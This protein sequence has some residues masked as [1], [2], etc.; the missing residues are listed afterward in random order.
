M[1]NEKRSRFLSIGWVKILY[2]LVYSSYGATAVYFSLYYRR[3]GLGSAEIGALLS[4]QPLVM[5]LAGPLW[6]ALADGLG[7]R[8]RLLTLV[9][10][11]SVLPML[12]M[13]LVGGNFWWLAALNALYALFLGPIQPLTDTLALD[14][15]GDDQR[16]R[17]SEIRAFGSLGYA[18]V[19]WLTGMW[20]TGHDIRWIFVGY[21]VL[22][23][24]GALLSVWVRSSGAALKTRVG[25]GLGVLLR[26][27]AWQVFAGALF[28]S[29][30]AQQVTFSFVGLYL[31][32]LGA[33]EGLIGFSS[34]LGSVT[35]TLLMLGALSWMLRRWGSEKVLLMAMVVYGVRLLAWA[36]IPSPWVVTATQVLQGFSFGAS[37]VAAVDFAARRAPEGL[38]VT[39][40][41][42]LTSLVFGLGRTV[43]SVL[44]G[45]L[46]DD[47]GPQ[48]TFGILAAMCAATAAW[49]AVIWRGK[50]QTT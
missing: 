33:S 11:A 46:Y 16:H 7:L 14:A 24:G 5:L 2:V 19:A 35:Q 30:I 10:G 40:Q 50:G 15:L 26:D 41:S 31:D 23:G 9:A 45:W 21:A 34:G 47:I 43:G 38:A 12:G 36:L 27:R 20:I 49:M 32:N 22:M 13:M 3:V 17:Y 37:L 39:A 8:S 6:S 42:L 25:A 4:L 44:A 18:P 28:I 29:Q 1:G 48:A